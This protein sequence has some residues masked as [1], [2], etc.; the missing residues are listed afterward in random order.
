MTG[1]ARRREASREGEGAARTCCHG[2]VTS[3]GRPPAP[4][5]SPASAELGAPVP[6]PGRLL[7]VAT[8]RQTPVRPSPSH[9]TFPSKPPSS[10][11]PAPLSFP[12]RAAGRS[13]RLSPAE[14]TAPAASLTSRCAPALA[15]RA[16]LPPAKPSPVQCSLPQQPLLPSPA[17]PVLLPSSLG[18]QEHQYLQYLLVGEVA[19][20]ISS[21][22]RHICALA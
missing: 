19:L 10:A 4:G 11:P 18:S 13:W 16:A 17:H 5:A 3:P 12:T 2:R 20:I 21:P 8:H 7:R 6:G 9:R 15:F 14:L 22:R 1:P